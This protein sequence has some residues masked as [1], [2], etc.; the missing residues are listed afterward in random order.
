[1][2]RY[3][4]TNQAVLPRV[5]KAIQIGPVW[6]AERPQ[7]GRYRQFLQCDIDIIGDGSIL[8][9]AELLSASLTALADLGLDDAVIRINHREVLIQ[10]ISKIGIPES[11]QLSAMVTIDKLDK[12]GIEG[13]TAELGEKFGQSVADASFEWLSNLDQSRFPA[14]LQPLIDAMGPLASKIRYDASLVRGMGYYTGAIFEIEHPLASSSIGGGGRYDSM[15]GKWSGTDAPAV[16]ISLGI[17]RMIE[18]ASLPKEQASSL[19]LMIDSEDLAGQALSIQSELIAQGFRCRIELR[20]K[21]FKVQMASLTKQ[22][23]EK[24]AQLDSGTLLVSDL[25]IRMID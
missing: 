15:V 1:L 13:V 9:E 10:S 11:E 21:N 4:A 25:D 19:A 17:E 22:G 7:K 6:R 20:Q 2:T 14:I 16:G 8:A 3:F 24:F 23:F 5:F 12:L 18:L